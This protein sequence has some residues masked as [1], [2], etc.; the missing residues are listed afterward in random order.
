M[1]DRTLRSGDFIDIDNPFRSNP[2]QPQQKQYQKPDPR[3]KE[4][5][6]NDRP[7]KAVGQYNL[8]FIDWNNEYDTILNRDSNTYESPI[9]GMDTDTFNKIMEEEFRDDEQV[10][11]SM[12]VIQKLKTKLVTKD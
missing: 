5:T 9:Y 8:N 3:I 4:P 11:K 12:S 1:V 6:G 2:K 10:E 7:I